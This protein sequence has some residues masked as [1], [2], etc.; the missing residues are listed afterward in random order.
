M[1]RAK[2]NFGISGYNHCIIRGI[3][4]GDIFYDEQDR[5]KFIN[6][7]KE[8]K[9]KDEVKIG[10]YT[11]MQNHVHL[12]TKCD[13]EK[14]PIFFHSV[15]ISYSSYF[16]KKYERVGHLFENRYKNKPIET[17]E[18]LR[19]VVKYI[20]FNPEK[21]G[22]CS[23]ENYKWSSYKEFFKDETWIDKDIIL[24]Y[25]GAEIEDSLNNFKEQHSTKIENYYEN[26][27]EYELV[28]K[29]TDEQVKDMIDIAKDR[30]KK[31]DN[32]VWEKTCRDDFLKKMLDTKG[33]SLNQLSRV[34]GINRKVLNRIKSGK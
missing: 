20:H 7:L 12:I 8:H 30:L 2:R 34:M 27:A 5:Y 13:Y 15:L 24:P 18:Y 16:N 19:N 26:F 10:T 1:P 28:N 6:V 22:I 29:L 25:Y 32:S 17:E 4:K 9:Q 14:L 33:V 11:L 3:N 31:K 23:V 21:A